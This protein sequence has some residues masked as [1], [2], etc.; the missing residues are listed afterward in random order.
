MAVARIV[1]IASKP[2]KGPETVS[3]VGIGAET[4]ESMARFFAAVR[5]RR[6]SPSM[7]IQAQRAIILE[8]MA[9]HQCFPTED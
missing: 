5:G 7:T 4:N 8:E 3:R 2:G 1:E 9:K 6:L